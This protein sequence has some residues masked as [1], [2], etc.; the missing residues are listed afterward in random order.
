MSQGIRNNIKRNLEIGTTTERFP[1][2]GSPGGWSQE[3]Q[4]GSGSLRSLT[5]VDL[6]QSTAVGQGGRN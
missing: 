6:S 1:R 2:R 5:G 3:A 4:F